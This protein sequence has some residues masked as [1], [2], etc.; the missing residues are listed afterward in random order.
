[1][2]AFILG[3]GKMARDIGLFLIEKNIGVTFFSRDEKRLKNL[4]SYILKKLFL[5]NDDTSK[6]SV[7][8][9][10]YDNIS[11]SLQSPEIVIET[12]NESLED[13][14]FVINCIQNLITSDTLLL[15]NSSSIDPASINPSCTGMHFFYPVKMTNFVEITPGKSILATQKAIE[16]ASKFGLD[17]IVG[18]DCC[19]FAIN[20]LLL[21]LESEIF[22]ALRSGV[23]AEVLEKSSIIPLFPAGHLSWMDSVGLDIIFA[24]IKNYV[25][26]MNQMEGNDYKEL[27]DCLGELIK[28]GKSGKKNSNGLLCGKPLPW[29][30]LDFSFSVEHFNQIFHYLFIHTCLRFI[31][32]G[33][34]EKEELEKVLN[35]VFLSNSTLKEEVEKSKGVRT[36]FIVRLYNERKKTYFEP[37][38]SSGDL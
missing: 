28:S 11:P 36:D 12:V 27:L 26:D 1:M 34:I 37:L 10:T 22:I 5:F 31:E 15:T 32:K 6:F 24:S 21:P 8:F 7:R 30:T 33:W 19:H 35:Q 25:L 9:T 38:T 16:F 17:F 18:K 20:K 13:K 4:E 29:K 14:I 3:S 2:E 23:P